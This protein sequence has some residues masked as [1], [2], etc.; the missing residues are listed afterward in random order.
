MNHGFKAIG[1]SI[2]CLLASLTSQ[3]QSSEESVTLSGDVSDLDIVRVFLISQ[4]DDGFEGLAG[5]HKDVDPSALKELQARSK[6]LKSDV[7][8]NGRALDESLCNGGAVVLNS[9]VEFDALYVE[10]FRELDR[11]NNAAT[12]RALDGLSAA[13]Y[14]FLVDELAS[15]SFTRIGTTPVQSGPPRPERAVELSCGRLGTYD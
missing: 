12:A 7:N 1:I 10:A 11:S 5:K 15:I 8:R 3:A 4:A 9:K 13:A 6:A 2:A 14:K